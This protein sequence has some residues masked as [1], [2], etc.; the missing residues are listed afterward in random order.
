MASAVPPNRKG[1]KAGSFSLQLFFSLNCLV[2]T[3]RSIPFLQSCGP[4]WDTNE[5]QCERTSFA[6]LLLFN[7]FGRENMKTWVISNGMSQTFFVITGKPI[8]FELFYWKSRTFEINSFLLLLVIPDPQIF[9]N[10][11]EF[12]CCWDLSNA[13][14]YI[15]CITKM[16]MNVNKHEIKISHF[17]FN[18]NLGIEEWNNMIAV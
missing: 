18:L 2:P 1:T 17:L 7:F 11:L 10:R 14:N 9:F 13:C 6:D 3:A 4:M 15:L 12:C 5:S 16:D 8:C